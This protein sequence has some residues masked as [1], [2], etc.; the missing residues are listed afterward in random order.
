[1]ENFGL[2]EPAL[3]LSSFIGIF[4]VM[5]LAEALWPRKTRHH[6]RW[7]RWPTNLLI[8]ALG[9]AVVRAMAVLSVPLVAVAVALWAEQHQLGLLNLVA[10]P[11]WFRFAVTLLLLDLLIWAQHAAFHRIPLFWRLHR[12]H[13][14]DRDIDAST[15]LRFHPVEI[16]LSMLIKCVAVL[17]LGAPAAAV[18]AFEIVLNGMALFNHA[19]L[20]LPTPVDRLLRRVLVTPDMHR[21]HHSIHADEHHRN[22][23]F[24]LSVW[25][26]WFGSYVATPRDGHQAMRIG[27]REY[28]TDAPA[29]LWWSL[30]LPAAPL[31]SQ[32]RD[33]NKD[34]QP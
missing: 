12:V 16:A 28:Q 11:L 19:N 26:R 14:A 32:P 30:W 13:H 25:D 27:L 9:A 22:F 15:A 3:R 17:A 21:V 10:W 20:S 23:G 7:R 6:P 24:N 5:S 1:M 33:R 31:P 2:S 18:M 29:R 8:M 34:W 4:I